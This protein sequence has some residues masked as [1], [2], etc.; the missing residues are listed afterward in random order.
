MVSKLVGMTGWSVSLVFGIGKNC[1]IQD[2]M[3]RLEEPIAHF[4]SCLPP[5]AQLSAK[6]LPAHE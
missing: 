4:S 1:G 2:E 6:V 5:F 3:G